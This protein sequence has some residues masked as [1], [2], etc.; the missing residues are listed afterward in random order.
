[1]RSFFDTPEYKILRKIL[2]RLITK[3]SLKNC[4][5]CYKYVEICIK[6][7]QEEYDDIGYNKEIGYKWLADLNY[8]IGYQSYTNKE[9]KFL[10]E[11]FGDNY[12]GMIA[13]LNE[14]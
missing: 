7:A 5:L 14:H 6:L 3:A 11:K 13:Y 12:D 2:D 8:P 10:I 9:A 1:M 4:I